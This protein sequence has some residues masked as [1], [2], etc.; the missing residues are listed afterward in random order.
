[1]VIVYVQIIPFCK[2]FM[3]CIITLNVHRLWFILYSAYN[4]YK[5]V[6]VRSYAVTGKMVFINLS[7]F[8]SMKTMERKSYSPIFFILAH[9]FN[10]ITNVL[11][12]LYTSKKFYMH[13]PHHQQKWIICDNSE[14]R[15]IQHRTCWK[16]PDINNCLIVN[17][18]LVV[19]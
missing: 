3:Y 2:A 16:P 12:S 4:C 6:R 9:A 19:Q 18:R 15:L 13:Y 8:D 11:S 14:H 17:H 1:M 7:W 10:A 5:E